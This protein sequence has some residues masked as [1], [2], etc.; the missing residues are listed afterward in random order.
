MSAVTQS[1]IV[2]RAPDVRLTPQLRDLETVT[3]DLESAKTD[4]KRNMPFP[5][6]I[7]V[8]GPDRLL[9]GVLARLMSVER[10]DVEVGFVPSESSYATAIYPPGDP[11]RGTPMKV[12]LIRDDRGNVLVGKAKITGPDGGDVTGET[13]VDSELL[14]TGKT[15]AVIVEP[16]GFAPGVRARVAKHFR[17]KWVEGRAAQ[18]GGLELVVTRD[19]QTDPSVLT[20]ATFYRHTEDWVLIT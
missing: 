5:H 4:L 19:G 8:A 11:L 16:T 3:V 13:F 7:I 9:A 1:T 20:R 18:T 15:R 10:L 2:V 12:P 14:F 17:R 6:R